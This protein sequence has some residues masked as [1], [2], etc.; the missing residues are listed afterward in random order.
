[1]EN[2]VN[3]CTNCG[4]KFKDN[5]NNRFQNDDQQ[6]ATDNSEKVQ[7]II[8]KDQIKKISKNVSTSL[9]GGYFPWLINS[10]KS[11]TKIVKSEKW[12]GILTL[13]I[14]YLISLIGINSMIKS[15]N[16]NFTEKANNIENGS[17]ISDIYVKAF[18]ILKK[19]IL[20]YNFFFIIV[21]I[22]ASY[23]VYR[24]FLKKNENILSYISEI[25]QYSNYNIFIIVALLLTSFNSNALDM[26]GICLVMMALTLFI[27]SI[28][29]IMFA[30]DVKRDKLLAVII[31]GVVLGIMVFTAV[32]VLEDW[33]DTYIYKPLQSIG[34]QFAA[35]M[36]NLF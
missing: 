21:I 18:N 33:H 28:S 7:P 35:I 31:C 8:N 20:T 19:D 30:K 34:A 24:F 26:L 22:L 13:V 16:T 17:S 9:R 11:P 14:E 23:I 6:K 27:G 3:F 10:V 32:G 29:P 5:S 4:Y 2:N 25:A 15:I 1:M 12:F 36:N